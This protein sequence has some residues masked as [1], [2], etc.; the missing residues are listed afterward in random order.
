MENGCSECIKALKRVVIAC[1]TL[2]N[3]H[4]YTPDRLQQISGANLVRISTG[5]D[6]SKML[7]LCHRH[8]LRREHPHNVSV[9]LR[10]V[11]FCT[12][13]PSDH[14]DLARARAIPRLDMSVKELVEAAGE[15][16]AAAVERLVAAGVEL[17]G[18]R[19]ADGRCALHEAAARGHAGV[20]AQLVRLGAPLEARD[21]NMLTPL[22]HAAAAGHL[23]VLKQLI[24]LG[25]DLHATA[26]GRSALQLARTFNHDATAAYLE[27][28]FRNSQSQQRRGPS[29][30]A[31]ASSS[32]SSS[33]SSHPPHSSSSHSHAS[34]THSAS[35]HSPPTA[36]MSRPTPPTG[37]PP[38]L[39]HTQHMQHPH[40]AR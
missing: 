22:L 17:D 37:A 34:S 3:N 38:G 7:T 25:A 4:K 19:I 35:H 18:Q 10:T 16:D 40:Y 12:L 20:V 33:S 2:D 9:A 5:G 8:S 15:G 21:D 26:E 28:L 31:S 11:G 39:Q 6:F 24:E 30:A 1:D 13:P 23:A 27:P 29:S 14:Q 32:G 36:T